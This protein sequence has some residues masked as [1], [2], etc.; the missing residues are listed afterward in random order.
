LYD[1]LET[2]V[3]FKCEDSFPTLRPILLE[4]LTDD[5]KEFLEQCERLNV[6]YAGSKYADVAPG[7]FQAAIN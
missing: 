6:S 5:F 4:H 3:C 7:T 2:V 1:I